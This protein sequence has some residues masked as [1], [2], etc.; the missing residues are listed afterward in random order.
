M[1]NRYEESLSACAVVTNLS[2]TGLVTV[3]MWLRGRD[4]NPRPLGYEPNELPDCS[5]PRQKHNSNTCLIS[6]PEADPR[7]PHAARA[8]NSPAATRRRARP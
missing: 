8:D 2:P 5:T 1:L 7:A 6:M 3:E 4:L